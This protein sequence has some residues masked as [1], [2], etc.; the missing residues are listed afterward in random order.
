MKSMTTISR[1]VWLLILTSV[2]RQLQAQPVPTTNPV[3]TPNETT[4]WT[5]QFAWANVTPVNKV[6][7]LLGP[8]N[9]VDSLVLHQTMRQISETGGGVVYFPAGTYTFTSSVALFDGV[10]LRGEAIDGVKDAKDELF[11]PPT[12]F[13]FPQYRATMSRSHPDT[14]LFKEESN[15]T[16]FKTIGMAPGQGKTIG[17]IDLD[18]DRAVIDFRADTDGLGRQNIML[19]SL[20]QN[21]AVMPDPTIPTQKQRALKHGWQRWPSK[22]VASVEIDVAANCLVSNCRLNDKP[23]DNYPQYGFTTDDG[24]SFDGARAVFDYTDHPGIRVR[25][26]GNAPAGITMTLYPRIHITTQP[27][28][29]SSIELTNNHVNVLEGNNPIVV[30]GNGVNETGNETTMTEPVYESSILDGRVATWTDYKAIYDNSDSLTYAG[31][32]VSAK[33][34][35]LPYRMMKPVNYDPT[36]K[37]PI[38]MYLHGMGERGTDNHEQLR[39]F[40]WYFSTEKNRQEHPCFVLM[41]QLNRNN[42]SFLGSE[43][44][45]STKMMTAVFSVMKRLETYYS[46]DTDRRYLIGISS[47]AWATW[48][49]IIR[50]PKTFAAAVPISGY[51]RFNEFDAKARK[52]D[53]DGIKNLP[54]WAFHGSDDEWIPVMYARMTVAMLKNGGGKPRYTEFKGIGH[55]CWNELQHVPEFMPWLFSQR[56]NQSIAP[57]SALPALTKLS[58]SPAKTAQR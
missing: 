18:I 11:A 1:Y 17:L 44:A 50:Y 51:K 12:R 25:A 14:L 42:M 34:D 32:F 47:G 40:I 7:G 23:D 2:C 9:L 56:R 16:A 13:E 46:I 37:Y 48:E 36:K 6:K 52:H 26:T 31:Q 10:V 8:D 20:R 29:V 24:H 41:P 22:E 38:V 58:A 33:G 54:I 57:G 19:L 30:E 4:Q 43:E 53:I 15:S 28:P 35:T 5:S 55:I 39:N 49:A 21:N 27:H 45:K 3:T